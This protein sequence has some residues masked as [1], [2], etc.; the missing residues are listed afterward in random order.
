MQT[1]ITGFERRPKMER[2]YE[3]TGEEKQLDNGVIVK[4]I[5]AIRSFG[6]VKAGDIGGW[7]EKEE[8]LSHDGNAWVA[9]EAIV[10]G[11]AKVYGDAQ[12][13]NHARVFGFSK[14]YGYAIVRD[15]AKVSEHT[16]VNNNAQ[17]YGNAK[18]SGN[19]YIFGDARVYGNAQVYGDA[20]VYGDAMVS[21]NIKVYGNR[22][23]FRSG[24]QE[25][26]GDPQKRIKETYLHYKGEEL[27]DE[28][29]PE[30]IV[31]IVSSIPSAAR[32]DFPEDDAEAADAYANTYYRF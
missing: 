25:M 12:V 27:P 7:I 23:I 8:N 2:K 24:P 14:V 6:S 29:L 26:S 31:K 21:G 4:R 32:C 13:Y 28:D 17:V 30:E 3:F 11:D 18:V 19:A 10:Y 16:S 15:G 22:V 5:R 1:L 20:R 9:D